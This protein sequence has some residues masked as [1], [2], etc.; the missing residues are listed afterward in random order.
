MEQILQY[1]DPSFD[2]GAGAINDGAINDGER[3]SVAFVYSRRRDPPVGHVGPPRVYIR[4]MARRLLQG[5]AP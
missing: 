1:D 2:M 5:F 4:Q 3:R